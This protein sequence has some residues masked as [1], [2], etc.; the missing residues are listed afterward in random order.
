MLEI[1]VVV[2]ERVGKRRGGNRG[3]QGGVVWPIQPLLYLLNA[4]VNQGGLPL[5]KV[6]AGLVT[7]VRAFMQCNEDSLIA[8]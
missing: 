2:Y 7:V 5:E 1:V 8:D 4:A 6:L 3:E